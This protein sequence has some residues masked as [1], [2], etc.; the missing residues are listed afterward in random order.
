[1][2]GVIGV[3]GVPDA[4]RVA[5]LGL[6][7]LQHRGQESAGI[8]AVDENTTARIHREMGLVAD[9]FSEPALEAL[10]GDV[11]IGHTRYSTAGST[12][13]ANAQPFLVNY[14]AG[15]LAVAHNGNLVNADLL[16]EELVRGGAIFSSNSDTEVLIHLIARSDAPTVEGQI[17]DALEQ[18]DG[19]YSVVI[20]V[21][22]TLYAAIDSRGFR[23]L[24]VGRVGDGL[25]AASETCA[26][27]LVGATN[28][29]EL[30]PG[31]FVRLEDGVVTN[32]APLSPRRVTRCI[33]EL[34][35]F[36]RP[37]S[38]IFGES[39]DRVRRELGRQLARFH[40]ATGAD[41]VF[42]VPDSANVMALGYSEVSGVKLEHGLIRNHYVG[43]TF[44]NPTQAIRVE[45]VK[46]K[47][48]AVRE[49]I[50]GKSVVVVDDSLVRG[51]TS[52]GLVEMIRAAGAREVHLRLGS[53]PIT[54]PC[55][56]GIDTPTRD[57]LIAATHSRDEIRAYLGV[58]SLEY[59]TLDE[60]T[61]A[62]SHGTEWCHACFSG[63]YPTPVQLTF[64]A[65]RTAAAPLEV[66]A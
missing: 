59:L 27:D 1:M 56:Y 46:I 22:R 7:A 35:Y 58:D 13:L 53:P 66:I 45:K 5:Y 41:V 48:N 34:V 20:G 8:M 51:T 62:T 36:S 63:D 57:E 24:F 23:P 55:H 32:L 49:V 47:F 4:S 52:K 60:M 31:E 61:G 12:V 30:E 9:A 39:V 3:S 54:G 38:T 64:G 40:P 37:D 11:A 15:P 10:H 42:S 19:A 2:C 44:I 28:M 21:G 17:R 6:Y 43:R 14:H 16:R 25:V 26:L 33:F 65:F 18:A 50:A 29:R